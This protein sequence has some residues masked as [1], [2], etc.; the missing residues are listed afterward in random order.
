MVGENGAG[1]TTIVKLLVRL[2]DPTEGRI[3]LDGYDLREFNLA[4]VDATLA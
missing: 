2:Y 4:D 3:L 1:K